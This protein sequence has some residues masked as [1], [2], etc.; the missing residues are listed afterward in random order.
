[1]SQSGAYTISGGLASDCAVQ[2]ADIG[3]N[4]NNMVPFSI[5]T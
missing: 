5:M 2:G 1:M 4:N 3:V